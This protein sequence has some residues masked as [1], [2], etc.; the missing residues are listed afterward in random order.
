MD[1]V[2]SYVIKPMKLTRLGQ[3]V[4]TGIAGGFSMVIIISFLA[5]RLDRLSIILT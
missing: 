4:R 2:V 5:D 3:E 1:V